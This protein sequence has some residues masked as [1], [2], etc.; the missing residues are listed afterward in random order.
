VTVAVDVIMT[1][2][3]IQAAA[4]TTHQARTA[5]RSTPSLAEIH[6]LTGSDE[7]AYDPPKNTGFIPLVLAGRPICDEPLVTGP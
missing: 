5:L 3:G 6:R 2:S 7:T 4:E 1:V